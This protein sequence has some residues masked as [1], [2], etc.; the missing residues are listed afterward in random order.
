MQ[1]GKDLRAWAGFNYQNWQAAA[2]FAAANKVDL[3]EALVWADKAISEPF[4]NAAQAR[5]DFS[6]LQTKAAVL[7]ARGRDADADTVMDRA[8]QSPWV[9]RAA[10]PRSATERRRSRAGTLRSSTFHPISR[11]RSRWFER[12]SAVFQVRS[13]EADRGSVADWMATRGAGGAV[14]KTFLIVVI[15]WLSMTFASFGLSAPRNATVVTVFVI[16]TLSVAAAVFLIFEL[17]SPFDGIIQISSEPF[18]YALA[19]LGH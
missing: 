18:R 17:D 6:T 2:Q 3:A 12:S 9:S 13:A 4:R 1:M 10:T 16:S 11:A 14:A 5:A 8:I 7:T 15:F 19:N